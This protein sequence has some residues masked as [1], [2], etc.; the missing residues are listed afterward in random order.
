MAEFG[1]VSVGTLQSVF[2]A[3]AGK[4]SLNMGIQF[5]TKSVIFLGSIT[6]DVISVVGQSFENIFILGQAAYLAM[7]GDVE[8][9]QV[10]L[11]D[12]ARE[13]DTA[14][15]N[16][17]NTFTR[18]TEQV[19][20]FEEL[21]AASTA[22]ATMQKTAEQTEKAE[23]AMSKLAKA[24]KATNEQMKELDKYT[25]DTQKTV[26]SLINQVGARG[27]KLIDK[28][29]IDK[30]KELGEQLQFQKS[31][32]Q[33]QIDFQN[34][35]ADKSVEAQEKVNALKDEQMRPRFCNSRKSK[36]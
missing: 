29:E 28:S 1:T 8:R 25:S 32:I 18:A 15:I 34:Q 3:I 26:D 24:A 31:L 14:F 6:K 36:T 35:N 33:D 21:S 10:L 11:Q 13:I 7:T 19:S 9:A 17:G 20:R 5:A 27:L 16:L 30:A 4:N 12:N 23:Q 2:D 22:P